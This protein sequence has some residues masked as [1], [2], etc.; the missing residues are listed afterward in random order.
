LFGWLNI[1]PPIAGDGTPKTNAFILSGPAEF[2]RC[3]VQ[4]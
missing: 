1:G 2:F 4:Y 3:V